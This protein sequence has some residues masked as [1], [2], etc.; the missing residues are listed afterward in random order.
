MVTNR[1]SDL[2]QKSSHLSL[3]AHEYCETRNL[4]LRWG[5]L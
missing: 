3:G 4:P 5:V 2:L 1:V